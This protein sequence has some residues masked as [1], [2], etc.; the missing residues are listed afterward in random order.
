MLRLSGLP[1]ENSKGETGIGQ[2]ELNVTYSHALQMADRHVVFKQCLKEIADEQNKS[3]TFMAKPWE[4]DAGSSC[5]IHLSLVD[6]NGCNVFRG[7]KT[8]GSV[9]GCSDLF[10]HFLGGWI[11]HTPDLYAFYA[12]TVNSYKRFAKGSWAPTACE[13]G[14]DNRTA[15]FRIVGSGESLRIE[16]R[17]PGADVNPYLAFAAAIASGMDGIKNKIEPPPMFVGDAYGSTAT[18]PHSL[19]EAAERLATSSFA[20]E[21]L[22]E[23]VQK[24]YSHFYKLEQHAY[25]AAVTDWERKR[26]FEQI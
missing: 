18:V 14:H 5:H 9:T 17:L 8:L 3:I 7:D 16:C 19:G 23:A 15:G 13:W 1:V 12:P 6:E 25:D 26:Y 21:T 24:H 20:K 4:N 11:K 22:G 2:H 10:K